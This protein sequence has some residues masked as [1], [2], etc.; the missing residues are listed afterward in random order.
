MMLGWVPA[1]ETFTP[2]GAGGQFQLAFGAVDGCFAPAWGAW[3]PFGCVGGELGAYWANGLNVPRPESRAAFWRAARAGIG[4]ARALS[5]SV[6]LI[7]QGTAVV[8]WPRPAFVLDGMK[9]VYRPEAVA[10]RIGAGL[11]FLF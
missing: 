5:D 6:E 2:T 11:A 10:F 9:P 3:T 1:R 7:L 4:A 8:P